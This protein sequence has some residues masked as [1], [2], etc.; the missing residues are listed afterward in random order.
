MLKPYFMSHGRV[1]TSVEYPWHVSDG[2]WEAYGTKL[3]R[4]II[5]APISGVI[6]ITIEI[7]KKENMADDFKLFWTND[8]SV[9]AKKVWCAE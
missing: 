6:A 4:N 3:E 2:N 8:Q 1:L 7:S 9:L 5:F